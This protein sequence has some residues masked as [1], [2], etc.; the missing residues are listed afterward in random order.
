[1]RAEMYRAANSPLTGTI[2]TG[3]PAV[4]GEG[5]NGNGPVSACAGIVIF[6]L[7]ELLAWVIGPAEAPEIDLAEVES[8]EALRG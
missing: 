7:A 3:R 8:P 6:V 2:G 4:R 5:S 1:M